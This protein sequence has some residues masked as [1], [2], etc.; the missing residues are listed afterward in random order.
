M[1][2]G[3]IKKKYLLK[4]KNYQYHSKL[5]YQDSKPTI[6]DTEFDKLK[7][8]ILELEE[9]YNFLNNKNSPSKLVGHK[10]SKSFEKYK[11]KVQ[12]L[13]LSNAFDKEDLVNFEKKI[14]NYLDNKKMLDY[15]VEPKIDE[16]LHL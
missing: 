6:S 14:F 13:S 3:E 8:E 1:N 12:M 5:Y 10:P 7:S 2:K 9:S 4:L 11:H 15:S 16:F